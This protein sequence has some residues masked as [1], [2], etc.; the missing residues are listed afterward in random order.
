[1]EQQGDIQIKTIAIQMPD[2][3]VAMLIEVQTSNKDIETLRIC[4]FGK[5]ARKTPKH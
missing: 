4:Q 2:V 5:S 3:E 1:M